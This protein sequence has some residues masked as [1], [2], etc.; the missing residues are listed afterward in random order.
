MDRQICASCFVVDFSTKELLMIYNKKLGKWL[1]PG[2]HI[3][4]EE[5]P[6][7]TA[8]REVKEETGI[9]IIPIG[10]KFQDNIEPFAVENYNTRIGK[11][12][13][14]QFIG[15]PQSKN[16]INKEDNNAQWISVEKIKTADNIDAEIKE[17][18]DY[19]LNT[20]NR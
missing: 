12:I 9:E 1:Q 5:A 17:K 11:M 8:I 6:L 3:E 2:G 20:F 14:I 15:V 13:D 16:I 10:N 4:G 19:I 7:Q 18:F